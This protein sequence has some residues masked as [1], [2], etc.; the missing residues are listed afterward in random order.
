M[1][2][3]QTFACNVVGSPLKEEIAKH[4]LRNSLLVAP[5]PTASTAQ[6]L[7]NNECFEPFTSNMYSR[8]TNAGDFVVYNKHLVRSLKKRGLW[9]AKTRNAIFADNG[10]IQEIPWIPDTLKDVFKTVWEIKQSQLIRMAAGRAPYVDQSMSLNL[11]VSNPTRATLNSLHF[12]SWKKKLK[13]GSYYIRRKAE[14][15]AT[16]F[17]AV[18]MGASAAAAAGKRKR[19][20]EE[21]ETSSSENGF[22]DA[23]ETAK[24]ARIQGACPLN[25]VVG[26]GDADAC[27]ACS[28]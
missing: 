19:K 17:N 9:D 25:S 21:E 13:T 14:T 18:S 24:K 27:E 11:H 16:S 10:S 2:V 22:A 4:G 28:G 7:G 12:L 20:H 15:S 26:E 5:M 3:D 8:R 1:F 6:L 23:V